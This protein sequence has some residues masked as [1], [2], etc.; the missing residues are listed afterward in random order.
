MGLFAALLLQLAF[1]PLLFG[2]QW[3]QTSGI[4]FKK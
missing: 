4:L 3:G 1:T 2:Q